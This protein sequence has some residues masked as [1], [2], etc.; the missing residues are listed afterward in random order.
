MILSTTTFRVIGNMKILII[1]FAVFINFS[2]LL[3]AEE[4]VYI[5]SIFQEKRTFA[6]EGQKV[7]SITA[8]NNNDIYASTKSALSYYSK[9]LNQWSDIGVVKK[10]GLFIDSNGKQTAVF[11]VAEN[12]KPTGEK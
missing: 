8:T 11:T 6:L 3:N 5:P 9:S 12:E 7:Y 2:T 4:K 1:I 10:P